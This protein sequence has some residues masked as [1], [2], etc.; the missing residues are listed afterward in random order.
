[1][2]F[3]YKPDFERYR[4]NSK[5]KLQENQN[6]VGKEFHQE[7]ECPS[8]FMKMVKER[9]WIISSVDDER[10]QILPSKVIWD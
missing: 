2:Q 6:Y 7:P 4:K 8:T 1:M 3:L 9:T 5:N 10:H